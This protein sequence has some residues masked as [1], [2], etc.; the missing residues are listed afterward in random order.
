MG[1]KMEG[2]FWAP[3][4]ARK[5]CLYMCAGVYTCPFSLSHSVVHFLHYISFTFKSLLSKITSLLT[6]NPK[7]SMTIFLTNSSF[8]ILCLD[9]AVKYNQF[10]SLIHQGSAGRCM[11]INVCVGNRGGA[12]CWW[13]AQAGDGLGFRSVQGY[14]YWTPPAVFLWP[15]AHE[16]WPLT[17]LSTPVTGGLGWTGPRGRDPLRWFDSTGDPHKQIYAH[18]HIPFVAYF[19]PHLL[20]LIRPHRRSRGRGGVGGWGWSGGWSRERQTE[21][22]SQSGDWG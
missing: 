22:R 13:T 19:T 1:V 17:P 8:H 15:L 12:G 10:C 4:G 14:H 21:R 18:T 9:N 20:L 2:L 6:Q 7:H 16:F 5:N 11:Y 3:L